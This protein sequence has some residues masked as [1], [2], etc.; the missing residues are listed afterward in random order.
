[1][2]LIILYFGLSAIITIYRVI[3]GDWEFTL[4]PGNRKTTIVEKVI[5]CF[6]TIGFILYVF[7]MAPIRFIEEE[8][9]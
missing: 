7:I 4:I 8:L 9:I 6:T 2:T 3:K 1:M 5:D